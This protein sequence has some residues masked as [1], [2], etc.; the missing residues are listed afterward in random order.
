[1]FQANPRIE[2]AGCSEVY[3]YY[4]DIQEIYKFGPYGQNHATNG[5][6]AVRASYVKKHK[7]NE[8]AIFAEE[9]SFLDDYK[10]PMIQLDTRKVMLVISHSD[11]TFD[12]IKFRQQVSPHV[13]K[14]SL[15]LRDFIK[16]AK[17]REFFANA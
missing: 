13:K 12:K 6:M 7:Y 2:L 17:I 16:P 4:S 15:K 1:M 10:N 3:M 5:T 8:N 14:T 9:R 11:N